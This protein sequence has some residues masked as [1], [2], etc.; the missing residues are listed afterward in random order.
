M[1]TIEVTLPDQTAA[2]IEEAAA[3]L[4]LSS[5]MRRWKSFFY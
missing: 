5:A 3:K 2:A 4:G 1:K